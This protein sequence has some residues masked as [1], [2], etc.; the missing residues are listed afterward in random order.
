MLA[1]W[2]E[3]IKF[4]LFVFTPKC[5]ITAPKIQTAKAAIK[6]IVPKSAI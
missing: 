4:Q 1:F 5:G 6:E 3:R 2:A